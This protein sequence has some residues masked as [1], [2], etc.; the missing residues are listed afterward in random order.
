MDWVQFH[1]PPV[2]GGL[3]DQ[4]IQLMKDIHLALTTY[5]YINAYRQA[6]NQLSSEGF[7]KFCNAYPDLMKFM[8]AVWKLQEEKQNAPDG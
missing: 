4:P 1:T 3:R 5:N 8:E 2:S 6:Q 7:I